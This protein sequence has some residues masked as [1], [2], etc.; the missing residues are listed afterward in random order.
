MQIHTSILHTLSPLCHYKQPAP[1]STPAANHQKVRHCCVMVENQ[2]DSKQARSAGSHRLVSAAGPCRRRRVRRPHLA[3]AAARR[4]YSL[5]P[6]M[7]HLRQQLAHELLSRWLLQ[8]LV[9]EQIELILRHCGWTTARLLGESS[10]FRLRRSRISS[11]IRSPQTT[12]NLTV[13]AL[14]IV[15]IR[16]RSRRCL[17]HV[18]IPPVVPAMRSTIAVKAHT[19]GG[20]AA[21]SNTGARMLAWCLVNNALGNSW[22][23]HSKR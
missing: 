18:Y 9:V 17:R 7:H 2:Q 20:F 15:F 4:H 12:Q 14:M 22:I 3:A 16:Q 1:I 8:L 5:L 23:T 13:W 19:A 6:L 11:S 10:A 21:E